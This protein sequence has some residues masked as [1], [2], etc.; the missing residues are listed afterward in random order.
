MM[1]QQKKNSILANIFC[2]ILP[3]KITGEVTGYELGCKNWDDIVNFRGL[4]SLYYDLL[5]NPDFMHKL[6]CKLTDIFIDKIKRYD[7]LGLFDGD[8]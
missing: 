4:D 6:V 1:K 7:S 8:S 3:V 2:D 5:D